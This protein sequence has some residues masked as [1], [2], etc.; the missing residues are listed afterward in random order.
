MII[1][2][3]QCQAR[4]RINPST[5]DKATVRVKCPGCQHTFEAR[6]ETKT[7]MPPVVA[8]A[9]VP[10]VVADLAKPLVLIVDDARFFREMICDLLA[11][12][13]IRME[14]AADGHEALQKIESLHP[15]LLLLDLNIPGMSGH[16]LIAA[17][18]QRPDSQQ[19]HILAMSG[20]QRGEEV[21]QTVRRLGADDFINKSFKPRDLQERIRQLLK[22]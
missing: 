4:Y 13:P 14:T 7:A 10:P 22:L 6:L 16:E 17:V 2:C 21:A 15:A 8:P 9:A 19:I 5:G 20:V 3:P 18:R 11:G 1:V 12:L